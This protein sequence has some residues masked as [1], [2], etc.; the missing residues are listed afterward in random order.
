MVF[1]QHKNSFFFE[2]K[3]GWWEPLAMGQ[4]DKR[5]VVIGKQGV[6]KTAL[7][8]TEF[9]FYCIE[10]YDPTIE[11]KERERP[12]KRQPIFFS[13]FSLLFL[14]LSLSFSVF[15]F[16]S[17]FQDT[18]RKQFCV[19]GNSS[20]FE[21]FEPA[22]DQ[23]FSQFRQEYSIRADG[24]ILVFDLTDPST[25]EFLQGLSLFLNFS[26]ILSFPFPF[27]SWF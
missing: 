24:F 19:E 21:I 12:Q 1:K 2:F 18:F 26:L 22:H 27:S 9:N 5:V 14:S 8:H 6:G 4:Q 15:K 10:E 25:L 23:I 13:A 17:L 16:V 7:F 20:V 3:V 11:G